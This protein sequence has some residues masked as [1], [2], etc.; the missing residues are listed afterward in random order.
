M[1]RKRTPARSRTGVEMSVSWA[2]TNGSATA[3]A[4]L[5]TRADAISEWPEPSWRALQEAGGTRWLVPE[6]HGGEGLAGRALQERYEWAARQCLTTAFILS[7][8]DAACRRIIAFGTQDLV[9]T[10]L[11]GLARGETF[12]TVGLSHLTTSRQHL[13]P[14]VTARAKGDGIVL[15][16]EV[17]WVTGASRLDYLVTG[18]MT[19]DGHQVLA[20]VERSSPGLVIAPSLDMMALAGSVTAQVRFEDVTVSPE[21][22]LRPT[23]SG[24]VSAGGLETTTLALGLAHAALNHLESEARVRPDLRPHAEQIEMAWSR[25]WD[26]VRA[27]ADGVASEHA[28][29][30]RARA[31]SLVLRATQAALTASKGAGFLLSH[32][33]QR[34]AR[35]AMFFLVWS[36]PRP[37]AEATL[38]L[39]T[40]G[41]PQCL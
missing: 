36:C 41:G 11:P 8:R 28:V 19:P 34:W 23:E 22:I 5:A 1:R 7:Q 31:N 6:A 17:P 32:P 3:L 20:L 37:T 26:E 40:P 27:Q 18:G 24:V 9:R 15:N 29:S 12:A 21:F 4:R 10:V 30:L 33:A 14:Q 13:A 38:Q 35:Q 2:P 16:G 39:L 25:I